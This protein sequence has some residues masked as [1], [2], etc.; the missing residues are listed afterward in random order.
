MFRLL[1]SLYAKLDVKSRTEA[2]MLARER[3]WL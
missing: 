1:R 3:G 2:L